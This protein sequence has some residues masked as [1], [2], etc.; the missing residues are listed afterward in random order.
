M[1]TEADVEAMFLHA[2][3]AAGKHSVAEEN[4]EEGLP[5]LEL[6]RLASI[7]ISAARDWFDAARWECV[8]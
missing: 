8:L 2:L 7:V 6:P 5:A 3:L 4:I 1:V